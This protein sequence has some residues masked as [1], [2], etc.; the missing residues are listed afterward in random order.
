MK[1]FSIRV[2]MLVFACLAIMAICRADE[3]AVVT[4]LVTD[5][6]GR[7]VP[8]VNILITNLAT[9]VTSRTATNDQ[10][11]YRVQ[12]LQP[13][14]YRMT[15]DKDGFKSIVKS[16][17][18]L[19]VQDVASI[20]FELQVGSVSETVTVQA[21]GMNINTTDASV[22]TVV[23]R[24]FVENM[25]L[26]GR[27][28]QALISLTPGVVAVP[29]AT[30]N[31]QGEFSVNGQRTEANYYTVDGV[32]A[33]TGAD[34]GSGLFRATGATPAA[35]TLGTT[36][37]LVS[38]DALQEFR[39]NTSTYSAEYGRTPGAQI[40]FQTRSGTR[41][42]H[43]SLF[44]Y[45]RNEVLDA[46]NWFNNAGGL[47]KTPEKH[48]DFGGTVGG[49]VEIPGLYRGTDKTFFFFSYEGL[50]LRVPQ[51]AFTAFVPNTFLRQNSPAEIQ[52]LLNSFPIQNGPDD[53]NCLPPG[54]PGADA[55]CLAQFTGTYSSPSGLDVY[56]I[57]VDHSFGDKLRI[58]GRYSD[59][60]SDS[61]TR[62]TFASPASLN[63]STSDVKSG[64]IGVTSIV[65]PSL[66]NE[67]RV[68]YTANKNGNVG[69][70]D[71]FAGAKPITTAE[72]FP[73]INVSNSWH[74]VGVFIFGSAFTEFQNFTD[75]SSQHQ[76]NLKDS[77][78]RTFGSHVMK[79]GV[80]YRRL[81]TTSAANA[82]IN[83]L[84][85]FSPSEVLS[86]SAS[87]GFALALPSEQKGIS[88]N[89]SLFAQDE[90][91]LTPRLNLS[92]GLRWDVNPPPEAAM[93][94]QPYTLDQITDLANAKLA[95][96]GTPIW[97]TDHLGF[98]PRFGVAYQLRRK[99]G[100][101]TV[102]RGGFGVFYDLGSSGA[103]AGTFNGVGFGSTASYS[104]VRFPLTQAQNTLPPPSADSP[105]NATVTAFD[106]HLKLPYTFEWNVAVQQALG[107]SQT[108]TVS[109][110]AAAGRR[111][112]YNRFY[113]L[114]GANPNFALG[115]GLNLTTNES[116]SNYNSLQ[117]QFQRRLSHGLQALASYS[118]S[119]SIDNVSTNSQAIESPIRGNSNFD[120]RHSFSA[121]LTYDVAGRYENRL[122]A[123]VLEHWG[124]DLRLSARSA[125]P[126]DIFYNTAF[127]PNGLQIDT[128]PDLVSGV[129]IYLHD[130]GAPGG[131][132]INYNAFTAPAGTDG[133]AP[134]NF[135]RG[136]AAWQA[137]L[138][139]RREFP[140]HE[141]LKLQ[142]RAESFNVLNH[143]SFDLVNPA[144]FL[145]IGP[146]MFGRANS[147]LNNSL[148]GLNPLY[149]TGG[150][151]SL[152]LA[153]RLL[154]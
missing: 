17:V 48:N 75:R 68:N 153:L 22:G 152:Q 37:S 138:A 76:W 78:S 151:R 109:Y 33:N 39:I 99:P 85:Y 84:L 1:R 80:D 35:T 8:G 148:G 23:D 147:T 29:G 21:G 15:L 41:D 51:P 61:L 45:F 116:S 104:D 6:N 102:V 36:H 55:N 66:A 108:L 30:A 146:S 117:V 88:R 111:L 145:V 120:V 11:I 12:S 24:Q 87:L 82:P 125:L 40:S 63:N 130:G 67:F 136:F 46:T 74:F 28:F 16:G 47:P 149:Q 9:N 90:W 103:L 144:Y 2:C 83:E 89:I 110:V 139:I 65:S 113:D 93:G 69:S 13:G 27:S 121:A 10:G 5:P 128:R 100:D 118:L 92:L 124:L 44:E 131:R 143:P 53:P 112:L 107:S 3:L 64:T 4:G 57:R 86:N 14:I 72:L 31:A 134:R 49:P 95:P 70:Q 91:K 150:P 106:P 18:E 105:Y 141:S 20:N 19:H 140:L 26:N 42:W 54:P 115:N 129:P 43:G 123:A 52:P 50:R 58:F 114:S 94:P 126:V 122:L 97:H 137:D 32:S 38:V 56:S 98:A 62:L 25:P 96:Q 71:N 142:F 34:G 133:N 135:V 77:V 127:L 79:F 101:E 59:S 60:S 81:M 119:H 7:S 73:D 132:L 154:F